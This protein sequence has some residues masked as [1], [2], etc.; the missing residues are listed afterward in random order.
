MAVVS[1]L[2]RGL[3][4]QGD[5]LTMAMYFVSVTPLIASLQDSNV[6]Q[7]WFADDATAGGTLHGLRGFWP[8]LQDLGSYYGYYPNTLKTWLIVKLAYSLDAQR[9]FEGTG[10]QVTVEG[11][12]HLGAAFGSRLLILLNS[13]FLRRWTHGHAVLLS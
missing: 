2:H 12:R 8:R 3:Y 4:T 7:V 9:L 5:P 11:K 13:M 1:F 6:K 10:V